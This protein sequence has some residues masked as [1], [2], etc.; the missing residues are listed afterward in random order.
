LKEFIKL[1]FKFTIILFAFFAVI[2]GAM[3]LYTKMSGGDIEDS[4]LSFFTEDTK[5][6]KTVLIAGLHPDGPLTDFI[7][8]A[9]YSPK[10]GK[11]NAISIPRDTKVIG[12]I[13]GKINSTYAK[14]RNMQ[15][16]VDKVTEVTSVSID[17]YV[18]IDTKMVK[19]MVDAVGGIPMEI[20]FDMKYDDFEQGLH[21]DL[22][23]GYQ[24]L[25]GDKAEQFIR[26]RKNNDGS[27]YLLG[28]V[29]RIDAQKEFIKSAVKTVLK[30]SIITKLPELISL[31][32][33]LIKTDINIADVFEYL[34]DVKKFNP[35]NLRIETLPG[36]GQY[37]DNISY[38][39]HDAKATAEL[40]EE[41]FN[42]I[43]VVTEEVNDDVTNGSVSSVEVS[44]ND[45]KV[46]KAEIS[47]EVLNGTSR[48]GLANSVA[49][50]LKEEGY[51]VTKIG[52]YKTTVSIKTS[53][54]NRTSAN[55]AKEVKSFLGK[56]TVKNELLDDA[57]VDVTVILG[58]DY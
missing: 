32:F 21:I 4:P 24:I 14:K 49:E 35:D 44:S 41:L 39:V 17:N 33:E 57:K 29:Q 37:I 38:F 6:T 47:V 56:G 16:L 43:D 22:K 2:L 58:S 30:P 23:K 12:S 7:L 53:I 3:V 13:D 26:F 54:I 48:N 40:V 15:D 36:E 31:G 46:S 1:I 34:D 8:L 50:K 19:K 20:P 11:I 10:S 51:N 28:D 42:N 18:L 25:N 55:Y 52:N 27:G 45:K 9:R 5:D